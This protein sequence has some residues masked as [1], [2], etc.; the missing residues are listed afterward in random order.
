MPADRFA[1]R[2][3][4]QCPNCGPDAAA[5]IQIEQTSKGQLLYLRWQCGRCGLHWPIEEKEQGDRRVKERRVAA[6]KRVP[7]KERRKA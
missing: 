6:R 4:K 3:P 2:I 1:F 7:A 5:S